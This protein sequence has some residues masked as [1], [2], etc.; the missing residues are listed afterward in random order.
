MNLVE[1]VAAFQ[2]SKNN[3][4]VDRLL[5]ES[6]K[7]KAKIEVTDNKISKKRQQLRFKLSDGSK[8]KQKKINRV[9][10]FGYES[11]SEEP[12]SVITK[13]SPKNKDQ[14]TNA[15]PAIKS[16]IKKPTLKS[17]K[18]NEEGKSIEFKQ[19][20]KEQ[21]ENNK[22]NKNDT[23]NDFI[24]LTN[25]KDSNRESKMTFSSSLSEDANYCMLKTYEDMLYLDLKSIYPD[26]T[27]SLTRTKTENFIQIPRKLPAKLAPLNENYS[28]KQQPEVKMHQTKMSEHLE[29]VN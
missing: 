15:K 1:Q 4:A 13:L 2:Y 27:H 7:M 21:I 8:Q 9:N 10:L 16:L 23:D 19:E 14:K 11:I 26:V 6:E 17:L 3:K 24:V 18:L 29:K 12:A 20:N 25:E 22:P 5:E 28:Y